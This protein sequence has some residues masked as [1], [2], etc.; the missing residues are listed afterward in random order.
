VLAEHAGGVGD[1]ELV[2]RGREYLRQ[3][4]GQLV[5]ERGRALEEAHQAGE[6]GAVC[7]ERGRQVGAVLRLAG[8]EEVR[9]ARGLGAR[10][11]AAL[12]VA[13]GSGRA[14]TDLGDQRSGT[15]SGTFLKIPV[16]PR[17]TALGGAYTALALS[18]YSAG[19]TPVQRLKARENVLASEKPSR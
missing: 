10:H 11:L 19:A 12:L 1:F 3:S 7:F 15:S 17:G 14:A 2:A 5:A 16:D 18:R 13:P 9:R 8:G 6:R 4:R